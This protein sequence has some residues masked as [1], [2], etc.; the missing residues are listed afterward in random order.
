MPEFF[1]KAVTTAGKPVEGALLRD[2]ER[3]VAREL[4]DMGLV[5]VYIG[6]G[7]QKQE[8]RLDFL[9]RRRVRAR[10]RL[11]FTQELSTLV[12]AGL[13]LDRAL[14]ICAELAERQALR[15]M[16]GDVLK[17]LKAG[18]TL[19]D[20]LGTHPEVFTGLFVSMVRAGEASG[21]L[22]V[23][24][25]R[26]TEFERAADELRGHLLSS[27]IYPALLVLVA[28]GSILVMMNYVVPTFAEMFKESQ[29]PVPTP[30]AMLLAASLALRQYGWMAALALAAVLVYARY[31]TTSAAGRRR[32]DGLKLRLPLAGDVFLKAETARFARTMATL[33][34]NGVPLVQSLRIVRGVLGNVVLGDSVATITLGVQRGEGIAR[35]LEKTGVFP[36]L[37]G[38]LL[39][40]GEETGRLDSMFEQM[41]DIYD[42][43]TRAAIK[44]A[45]ALFEPLV[46]LFM[47]LIVGA[48][49]LSILVAIVSINEVPM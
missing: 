39:T 5:P 10:D 6:T 8:L 20:S 44:R 27:L 37:A 46:I 42:R 41:A 4:R 15:A 45:T 3:A 16:I 33:V 31:Y 1:Y 22:G 9:S 32:W 47:G 34:A 12:N 35:P 40:V 25:Q 48:M 2:T 18:K 17:A 30:T 19:A 28:A 7:K 21:S 43:D 29:L 38:H 23:V 14:S 11:F 13:P 26:L 36:P 49:V 24:L